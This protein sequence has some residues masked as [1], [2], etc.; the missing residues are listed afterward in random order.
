M[1][2]TLDYTIRIGSTPTFLYFNF[3]L[4]SAYAHTT[5]IS[6]YIKSTGEIF[7]IWV[8]LNWSQIRL[9]KSSAFK[10]KLN[11]SNFQLKSLFSSWYFVVKLPPK[12]QEIAFQNIR[13]K[14]FS[15]LGIAPGWIRP[16][17]IIHVHVQ[18]LTMCTNT[19]Y[20]A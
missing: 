4:Y 11:Q 3:Y 1:L 12:T 5:F 19:G 6:I 16:C 9:M 8:G 2:E 20:L 7:L 15:E 14:K 10:S 17:I 13:N 18:Y